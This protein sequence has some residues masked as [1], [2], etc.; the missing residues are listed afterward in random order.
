MEKVLYY[1]SIIKE[2]WANRRYRALLILAGYTIIFSFVIIG[3]RMPDNNN[4]VTKPKKETMQ[5][6]EVSAL[7]ND[8]D[9]EMTFLVN[10]GE[11][12]NYKHT[13]D[14]SLLKIKNVYYKVYYN[15]LTPY[16]I[17]T[18][19][20][21][22]LPSPTFVVK[23]W[24]FNKS[25]IAKM[26][27]SGIKESSNQSEDGN[28]YTYTVP[29]KAVIEMINASLPMIGDL[30]NSNIKMRIIKNNKEIQGASLDLTEYYHLYANTNDTYK[31]DL[32]FKG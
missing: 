3:T 14:L 28:E 5:Q 1:W 21:L 4:N 6:N 8:T 17:K 25:V 9:Y 15:I 10:E 26:I 12:Y 13:K 22:D 18:S 27:N 16:D 30:D 7:L 29:C 11:L 31:L 24:R 2:I 19:E 23:F 32:E 20:E